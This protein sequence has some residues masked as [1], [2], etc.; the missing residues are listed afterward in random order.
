MTKKVSSSS[1]LSPTLLP[2]PTLKFSTGSLGKVTASN[3][4]GP[5][6]GWFV[7]YIL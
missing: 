3:R 1:L 4:T 5:L 7:E 6:H 2:G